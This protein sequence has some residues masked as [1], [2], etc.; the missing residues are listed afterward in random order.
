METLEDAKRRHNSIVYIAIGSVI[1]LASLLLGMVIL[2]GN[3]NSG[4]AYGYVPGQTATGHVATTKTFSSEADAKAGSLSPRERS[5]LDRTKTLW[6]QM[7]NGGCGECRYTD[8]QL[9]T[10]QNNT[11]LNKMTIA[12]SQLRTPHSTNGWNF[13]D[14]GVGAKTAKAKAINCGA[15]AFPWEFWATHDE[16]TM[17]GLSKAY[18]FHYHA[19]VCF[20]LNQAGNNYNVMSISSD[21]WADDRDCVNCSWGGSVL[22]HRSNVPDSWVQDVRTEKIA[23]KVELGN[24]GLVNNI[25]PQLKANIFGPNGHWDPI[26]YY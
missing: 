25:D 16:P 4:T 8:T 20:R 17:F 18:T 22:D 5:V 23:A 6:R 7:R 14:R 1:T 2:A 24:Y 19:D 9:A 10:I 12:T 13:G 26:P 15:G 11:W 3:T 21:T